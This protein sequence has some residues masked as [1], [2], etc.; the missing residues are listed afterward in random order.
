MW[1]V[2]SQRPNYDGDFIGCSRGIS[3]TRNLDSY[4]LSYLHEN[5]P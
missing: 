4:R 1:G 2:F 5:Q 3:L